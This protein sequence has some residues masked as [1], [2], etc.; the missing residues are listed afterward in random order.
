MEK[1]FKVLILGKGRIGRA[2]LFYLKKLKTAK[3]VVVLGSEKEIKNCDLLISALPGSAGEK[4]LKLALEYKKDLI[5]VSVLPI[6]FYMKFKNAILKKGIMVI[7]GCG[8]SP[9]LVNL[10]IGAEAKK[11]Q[12][13]N[14]IEIEAG[15]LPQNSQFVFPF[16]WCFE[17][18]IEEHLDES[19]VIK[20]GKKIT[21]P[22][23]FG[24]RKDELKEVGEF[25]SYFFEEWTSLS[26]S[27]KVKDLV[28]RVIRPIG[29][30]YFIQFLKSYGF[31]E[32]ENFAFTKKLLTARQTDNVTLAK[33]SVF[34]I[35]QK[36][37]QEVL[38]KIFSFSKKKE[39]LNSMQKITGIIPAV[40][41]NF[42]NENKIQNKGILFM[43]EI[44]KDDGLFR[45]IL[46]ELEKEKGLIVQKE[47]S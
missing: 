36:K 10:I 47:N 40:I 19:A 3:K 32:K 41:T 5:D 44:G 27:F 31:F 1:D 6:P 33:V 15:T 24:Y 43:E 18:L 34:G 42:I 17:D 11:F 9:G 30:L 21:L 8:F 2:V 46:K 45:E 16:T 20:N 28:F 4:G 26:Y 13:I 23:F 29:F 35:S 7:P 25:E 22:A 14:K 12:R 38:W 39:I 37:K